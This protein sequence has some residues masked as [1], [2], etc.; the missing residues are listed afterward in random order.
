MKRKYF[1]QLETQLWLDGVKVKTKTMMEENAQESVNH[2]K[3]DK[4]NPGD[5]KS[6]LTEDSSFLTL[7][8]KYREKY[9]A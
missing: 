3:I 6:S 5:M 7:F 2:W 8:P 4:F 9:V 1:Q